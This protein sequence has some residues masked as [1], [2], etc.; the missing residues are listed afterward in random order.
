[1]KI[2]RKQAIR[3][4][5]QM[6]DQDDPFWENLFID[7]EWEEVHEDDLPTIYDVMEAIGISREEYNNTIK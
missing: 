1:M 5:E 3:L 2:T 4:I 7:D 6:T